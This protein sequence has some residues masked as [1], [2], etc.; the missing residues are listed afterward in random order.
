MIGPFDISQEKRTLFEPLPPPAI[1]AKLLRDLDLATPIPEPTPYVTPTFVSISG[2]GSLTCGLTSDQTVTCWG[3]R[4]NGRIAPSD[5][6]TL[7][8]ISA[9]NGYACGL[10]TDG[11]IGCWGGLP[12]RASDI[13]EGSFAAISN[14]TAHL[15]AIRTDGETVCWGDDKYGQSTPP[16]GVQLQAIAVRHR[17]SCGL[18]I[19]GSPVC[20]GDDF[21]GKVSP[22][23]GVQLT[24]ISAGFGHTS[25]LQLDGSAICWGRKQHGSMA[26]VDETLTQLTTR[27]T[28]T[29]GLR[30][31]GT[32]VCWGGVFRPDASAPIT[33]PTIHLPQLPPE[34]LTSAHSNR[35]ALLS[36]G[37]GKIR[38]QPIPR[39]SIHQN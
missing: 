17:H 7:S 3:G 15:C 9:G 12:N 36:V 33:P 25:G 21:I 23:L 2:G 18:M 11:S 4:R 28:R 34:E 14:H 24:A 8:V 29:C 35:V 37:V 22:P 10:Q 1:S 16:A 32:A 31:D 6:E 13:P 20:W 39:T 38:P 19:D 5:Q 26:P 27:R 30:T